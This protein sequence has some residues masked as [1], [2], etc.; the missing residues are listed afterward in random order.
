MTWGWNA[1]RP[2]KLYCASLF[3]LS[4]LTPP[5][6]LPHLFMKCST[7][8]DQRSDT[9]RDLWTF[10]A[11]LHRTLHRISLEG[12]R[13][14]NCFCGVRVGRGILYWGDGGEPLNSVNSF[15]LWFFL[16][17][18]LFRS[19]TFSLWRALM[20]CSE[21]VIAKPSYSCPSQTSSYDVILPL[22]LFWWWGVGW[23]FFRVSETFIYTI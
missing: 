21:L 15:G 2:L 6:L 17:G 3:L 10:C 23:S 13:H 19:N 7:W 12:S 14:F 18:L 22:M 1:L 16:L 8:R 5:P 9:L 11:L 4:K 20:T